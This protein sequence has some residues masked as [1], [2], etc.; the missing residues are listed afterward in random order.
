MRL[1]H[2]RR[3]TGQNEVLQRP[4]LFVPHIDGRLQAFHFRQVQRLVTGHRQLATQ[5]EQ[6]VLT[7]RQHLGHFIQPV[8]GK[9]RQQQPQLA[10]QAVHLANRFDPRVVLGHPTAVA[11]A[12]FAFVAGAG[13]D[14]RKAVAHVIAP[15]WPAPPLP[16]G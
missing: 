4:Q 10:V 1:R 11:Q 5:V 2:Q 15:F 13:I 6:A 7:R 9:P 16:A 14:L 3:T 12:G 8:L